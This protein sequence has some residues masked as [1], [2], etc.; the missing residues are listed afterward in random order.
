[1]LKNL[2]E[3]FLFPD[4]PIGM[5]LI[6]QEEGTGWGM[7]M[8]LIK[9]DTKT[10]KKLLRMFGRGYTPPDLIPVPLHKLLY[11]VF[12]DK[13]LRIPQRPYNLLT[14]EFRRKDHTHYMTKRNRSETWDP[15]DILREAKV[16]QYA[17][18]G[19]P[20]P[21][22]EA[23]RGVLN[24]YMPGCREKEGFGGVECRERGIWLRLYREFRERR[25][26]VCG[27]GFE[28][29]NLGDEGVDGFMGEVRVGN[30][31]D[32]GLFGD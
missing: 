19:L 25:V 12:G 9:P 30:W 18:K 1:M 31:T 14:S 16:L 21:W 2:D 27:V 10:F 24:R 32:D 29:G 8:M 5:P 20:R 11:S 28:G 17:D 6:T 23:E 15:D 26:A 13:I 22:V 7:G 3:L 4:A